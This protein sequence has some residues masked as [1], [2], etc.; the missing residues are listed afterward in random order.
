MD[1]KFHREKIMSLK[2]ITGN[3]CGP[4]LDSNPEFTR[5]YFGKP[6]SFTFQTRYLSNA[7]HICYSLAISLDDISLIIT[8]FEDL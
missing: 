5:R 2:D 3:M 8:I 6:L 4:L 1:N 7:S